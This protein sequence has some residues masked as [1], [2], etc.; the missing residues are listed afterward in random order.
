MHETNQNPIDKVILYTSYAKLCL[1]EYFWGKGFIL[2]FKG[3]RDS[4][5]VKDLENYHLLL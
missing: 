4:K 5:R 1:F 2:A 3:V